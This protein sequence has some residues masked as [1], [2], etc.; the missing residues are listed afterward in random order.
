MLHVITNIILP[1]GVCSLCTCFCVC[2]ILGHTYRLCCTFFQS[3]FPPNKPALEITHSNVL[4]RREDGT[5]MRAVPALSSFFQLFLG[6]AVERFLWFNVNE[7][8]PRE[9]IL[10]TQMQTYNSIYQAQAF[11]SFLKCLLRFLTS[12]SL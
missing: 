12:S 8:S 5:E 1:A 2:A 11:F 10:L 4:E 6:P 3:P 9:E 7:Q